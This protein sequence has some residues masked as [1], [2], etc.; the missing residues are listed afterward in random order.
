MQINSIK[1]PWYNNTGNYGNRVT[2]DPF[3]QSSTWKRTKESFKRGFSILS[4]GM[5]VSNKLCY[6][7]MDKHNKPTPMHTVDH[8]TAIQDGGDRTNHDNLRSLCLSHHNSK[9]AQ[10]GNSRRKKQ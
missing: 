9:S 10:E 6:D 5:R 7:C 4:N 3:Y 2:I 1:R 8:M